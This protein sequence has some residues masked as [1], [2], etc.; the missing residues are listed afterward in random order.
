VELKL[1][2]HASQTTTA[3]EVTASPRISTLGKKCQEATLTVSSIDPIFM[4]R[5]PS[6]ITTLPFL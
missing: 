6:D 3:E 1:A 5:H 4:H 2:R